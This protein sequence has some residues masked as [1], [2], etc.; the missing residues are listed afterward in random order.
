M[1]SLGH[2]GD[3]PRGLSGAR[4]DQAGVDKVPDVAVPEL[5]V[6]LVLA[7]VL[8]LPLLSL[9]DRPTTLPASV[10]SATRELDIGHGPPKVIGEV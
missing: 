4:E 5:A 1:R 9:L 2:A 3:R 10:V 8:Q 6:D 7:A